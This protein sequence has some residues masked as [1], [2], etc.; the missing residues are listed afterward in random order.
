MAEESRLMLLPEEILKKIFEKI[1]DPKT[2]VRLLTVN[3]GVAKC[4]LE[5]S[6]PEIK[7]IDIHYPVDNDEPCLLNGYEVPKEKLIPFVEQL[8]KGA[9]ALTS[10]KVVSFQECRPIF[11]ALRRWMVSYPRNISDIL[12]SCV[13]PQR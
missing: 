13:Q 10:L 4:A 6:F 5:Y 11:T 1:N 8:W 3:K 12:L 9:N 7:K 2:L